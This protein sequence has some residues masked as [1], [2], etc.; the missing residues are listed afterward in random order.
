MWKEY[1]AD[2]EA[3]D[4]NKIRGLR[5]AWWITK[6]T[7]THFEYLLII[8]FPRQESYT[9]APHCY[10]VRALPLLFIICIVLPLLQARQHLA[11]VGV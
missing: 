8:V 9:K 10:I 2:R 4:E 5:F 11:S 6:A 3:T 7:N 1:G